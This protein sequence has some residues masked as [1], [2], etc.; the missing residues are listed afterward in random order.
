MFFLRCAR[1]RWDAE[2]RDRPSRPPLAGRPVRREP[3]A[4]RGV[5]RIDGALAGWWHVEHTGIRRD[6]PDC[7]AQVG[8]GL[9][10]HRADHPVPAQPRYRRIPPLRSASGPDIP[11]SR[12]CPAGGRYRHV[13]HQMIRVDPRRSSFGAARAEQAASGWL[14][15]TLGALAAPFTNRM[16]STSL[17]GM[18]DRNRS[19]PGRALGRPSHAAGHLRTEGND[20][21]G[22]RRGSVASGTTPFHRGTRHGR[23]QDH[24]PAAGR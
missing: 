6:R 12:G 4:R 10:P 24:V 20:R 19:R 5:G 23:G 21:A 9:C 16:T 8:L 11:R 2:L 1:G 13:S 3:S 17:G 14:G 7:A 15:V 18:H 22:Q